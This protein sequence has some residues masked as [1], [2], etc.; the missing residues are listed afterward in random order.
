MGTI[1][2]G[3]SEYITI[4]YNC[5]KIDYDDPF[6]WENIQDDFEQVE[7]ILKQYNFNY[8]NVKLKPG[9]YE[10]FYIDIKFN[11]D[12]DFYGND[13][14]DSYEHKQLAQK[15]ITQIKQF[16]LTCLDFG[17]C[18]VYPG[19][20]M[21]YEDRATTIREIE[22]G[23]YGMRETVKSTPTWNRLQRIKKY[24]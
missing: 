14:F 13:Y 8:F 9:Y 5:N 24:A 10:G 12:C 2:Y 17:C 7:Y 16:L 22:L 19:W 21:R 20:C 15:E 11:C 3:T 4:G 6:Y 1:N 18:A 23:V